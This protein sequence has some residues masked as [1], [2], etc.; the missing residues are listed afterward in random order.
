MKNQSRSKN[1]RSIRPRQRAAVIPKVYFGSHMDVPASIPDSLTARLVYLDQTENRNNVGGFVCSWR[2]RLNSAYDPDPLL[3][4]GAISGFNEWAAFYTHYRV[5]S[6]SYDVNISNMEAFPLTAVAAPTLTDLGANSTNTITLPEIPYGKKRCLSAKTGA[7]RCRF[8]GTVT[9]AKLEGSTEP[10]TD[11]SFAATVS[12][13]PAMIRFMNFGVSSGASALVSG[14]FISA[15]LEYLVQFY[16]R[17][18]V[19]A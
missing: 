16:A 13:N 19:F 12:T 3:G 4:T 11:S 8:R 14:V 9:V 17:V 5:L 18:P 10:F 2:Y 15:R 6:L 1:Y 7:D